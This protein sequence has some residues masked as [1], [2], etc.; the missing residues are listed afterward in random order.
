MRFGYTHYGTLFAG[1]CI[2]C[3]CLNFGCNWLVKVSLERNSFFW[4]NVGGVASSAVFVIY[5]IWSFFSRRKGDAVD[6]S[7]E[8]K[9][10]MINS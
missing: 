2:F 10:K 1:V 3:G 9:K 5:P 8:E 7:D 6:E 4:V